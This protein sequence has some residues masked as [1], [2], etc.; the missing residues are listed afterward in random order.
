MFELLGIS[1]LPQV[2][3]CKE[4]FQ[5]LEKELVRNR[6][7]LTGA[8]DII[9]QLKYQNNELQKKLVKFE[10]KSNV[11]REKLDEITTKFKEKEDA[12]N[13][14]NYLYC[15][16]LNRNGQYEQRCDELINQITNLENEVTTLNGKSVAQTEKNLG[17]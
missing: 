3:E 8:N 7:S 12:F 16:I 14:L 1:D 15:E 5:E 13:E 6:S 10:R 4:D 9:S 11:N 2:A 17:T